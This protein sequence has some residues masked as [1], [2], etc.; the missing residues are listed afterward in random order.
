MFGLVRQWV[1][2]AIWARPGQG[3]VAGLP[4]RPRQAATPPAS[5]SSSTT[6]RWRRFALCFRRG[7]APVLF[8]RTAVPR[9]SRRRFGCGGCSNLGS[10]LRECSDSAAETGVLADAKT[11]TPTATLSRR[12]R[13]RGRVLRSDL[14]GTGAAQRTGSSNPLKR[15]IEP[16]EL[17]AGIIGAEV[18]RRFP[19]C[20]TNSGAKFTPTLRPPS[21]TAPRAAPSWPL[22]SDACRRR[23]L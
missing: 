12:Q 11:R 7:L 20:P 18:P 15:G 16:A 22:I 19:S 8:R 23:E 3:G 13:R 4:P 10:E 5:T 14:A 21:P 1:A 6:C 9:F 17:D 2:G